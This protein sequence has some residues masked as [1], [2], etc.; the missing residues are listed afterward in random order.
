MSSPAIS[1]PT[2]LTHSGHYFSFLTPEDCTFLL[3]DIAH[4]LSNI[5]RFGGQCHRFYSVAEH[6]VHVAS[7][8]RP[9][10][11]WAALMHDAAE[12]FVGDMP[13]PLKEMLPDYQVIEKRVEA[14]IAERFGLPST[15]H[16]DIKHADRVMLRTEQRQVMNNNDGWSHCADVEPAEITIQFLAPPDAYAAFMGTAGDLIG[17]TPN[18]DLLSLTREEKSQ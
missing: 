2:I 7:L 15:M 6:S 1:G 16:P 11:R 9:E 18:A 17:L 13:K 4:G 3:S 10:L 8:V 5:C 14:V 12:A